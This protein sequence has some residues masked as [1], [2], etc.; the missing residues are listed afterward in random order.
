MTLN[1]DIS[2]KAQKEN[3]VRA[4]M[5]LSSQEFN[6]RTTKLVALFVQ[7]LDRKVVTFHKLTQ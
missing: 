3:K 2:L 1:S 4:V 7:L 6:W 5:H